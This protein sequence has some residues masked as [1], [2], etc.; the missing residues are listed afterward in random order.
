MSEIF[1][2]RGVE[3]LVAAE[4][5]K[6]D[7]NELTYGPVFEICGISNLSRTTESSSETKYY[8]NVPAL[9]VESTGSDTVTCSVSG[10][11][12]DVL[13]KITGMKY[14]E[15]LGT[16]IEGERE[17]KYFALGYKTKKTNGDEVY[18]WRFKG[19]FNIPDSTHATQTAGTE[20]NGQEVTYTGISTS[21]FFKKTG[22]TAKA[23]NVDL[24]AGKADVSTFFDSV[25][26]I[27]DL[28]STMPASILKVMPADTFVLGKRAD[29]L[30]GNDV[31]VLGD[32]TVMG[33]IKYVDDYVD[34]SGDPD[35]QSGHYFPF[36]LNKKGT[37]MTLIGAQEREMAWDPEIVLKVDNNKTFTIKVDGEIVAKL[38]FNNATLE[39]EA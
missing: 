5:F 21:H 1:E 34:F 30:V 3:N 36:I 31:R 14:D 38:K 2:W 33:T 29:E 19:K 32:G 26:T 13:A 20:S 24:G 7:R 4:L 28:V 18:V 27:D 8:N 37:R 23:I 11:P 35:E 12:L 39:P 17:S 6:D 9:V 15:T 22:K 16:L 10:V 25:T